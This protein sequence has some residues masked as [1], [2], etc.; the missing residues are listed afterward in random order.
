MKLQKNSLLNRIAL[1][2]L[3]LTAVLILIIF[4]A[5]YGEVYN[6]VYKH[7]DEDLDI[8][9]SELQHSILII[10]DS[11][12]IANKLEWKE[13]EHKQIEVNPT[14]MQV[15][16]T[17]G[18]IILKTGNLMDQSLQLKKDTKEIIY[19]NTRL[20]NSSIRQ[21]QKP[22]FDNKGKIEGYIV[23][24]IP[25]EDSE[26][27]LENLFRILIASFPIILIILFFSTRIIAQKNVSPIEDIIKTSEL[28]T[29]EN[30]NERIVLPQNEDELYRLVVT[31]NSLLDRLE[32]TLIR[33]KQ[34]TSDASHELRTP[35][36]TI[37]GTL[38]VL[39]RKPRSIDLYEEK[40]NYCIR[41][42]DHITELIEQL[43]LLARYDA[44]KI[45]PKIVF[46]NVEEIID[47]LLLR[48][49]MQIQIK[50]MKVHKEIST[51]NQVKCDPSLL[52][53]IFGN[54]IENSIKYSPNNTLLQIKI[55]KIDKNILVE[56]S[57]DG[58]GMSEEQIK[59]V[60]DRF[61]RGDDSRNHTIKGL[62]LG[63]SIVKKLSELLNLEVK[64]ESIQQK[65]TKIS[66]LIPN[67]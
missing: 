51:E 9:A 43:L 42:V 11:I 46:F 60:F 27:V 25:L 44:G 7:L 35:L 65:G 66:F 40:I 63:L 16:D 48:Y 67:S 38:E 31:I 5:V 39:I 23:L 17:A 53:I 58:Y 10:D 18:N 12:L 3:L 4:I 1:N 41:E 62:G 19:L 20:S 56:F 15:M 55:E 49:N 36:A 21:L 29:R 13:A 52:E 28:I 37:R 34:F 32:D 6:T 33:E 2:Y 26:I 30:L 50:N 54:V 22:V 24:A 61:Y 59:K 64:V 14:F 47:V 45:K 8:E 57:D